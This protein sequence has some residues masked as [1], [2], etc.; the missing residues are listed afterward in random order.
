MGPLTL[1]S[2]GTAHHDG[3]AAGYQEQYTDVFYPS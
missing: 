3:K 1:P 2:R